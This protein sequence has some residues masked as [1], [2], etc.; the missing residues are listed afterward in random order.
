MELLT[1]I[2]S[3]QMSGANIIKA[4]KAAI[5]GNKLLLKPKVGPK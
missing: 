2:M 1:L 5:Y 3:R 4:H